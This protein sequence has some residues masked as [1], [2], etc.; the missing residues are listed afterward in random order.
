MT[1]AV[2]CHVKS[3]SINNTCKSKINHAKILLLVL[4]ES[5]QLCHSLHLVQEYRYLKLP[6]YKMI[7][8]GGKN[9]QPKLTFEDV[10]L[11]LLMCHSFIRS[12]RLAIV[13]ATHLLRCLKN[14][15][16]SSGQWVLFSDAAQY[17]IRHPLW[18]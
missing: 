1:L 6:S 10:F 13:D 16:N 2:V 7:L 8:I 15:S 9:I 5:V 3:N 14:S 17:S 18:T 12:I 4:Q 11:N